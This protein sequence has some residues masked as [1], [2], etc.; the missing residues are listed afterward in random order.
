MAVGQERW[1]DTS[2][3]VGGHLGGQASFAGNTHLQSEHFWFGA[4]CAPLPGAQ[5]AGALGHSIRSEVSPTCSTPSAPSAL[6]PMMAMT[7]PRTPCPPSAIR[8]ES[9]PAP[10]GEG[11]MLG[12]V[13]RSGRLL[14]EAPGRGEVGCRSSGWLST[15]AGGLVAMG[16]PTVLESQSV[17]QDEQE[18][19][20]A[21]GKGDCEVCAVTAK[22]LP[23]PH[24]AVRSYCGLH[25]NPHARSPRSPSRSWT[26]LSCR[27]TST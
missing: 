4:L 10:A 25:G 22:P 16:S 3:S 7:C 17:S 23:H 6:A 2:K 1:A 19:P 13:H 5:G 8:G 11:A 14:E 27:T 24:P 20:G 9:R 18:T 26:L 12:A 21:A 15:H